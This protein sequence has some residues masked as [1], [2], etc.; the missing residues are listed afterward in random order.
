MI[1]FPGFSLSIQQ[2]VDTH[3]YIFNDLFDL[4]FYSQLGNFLMKEKL[5]VSWG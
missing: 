4:I 1:V 2:L 3:I 5:Y